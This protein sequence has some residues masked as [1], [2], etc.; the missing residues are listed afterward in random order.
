VS[1]NTGGVVAAWEWWVE[2]SYMGRNISAVHLNAAGVAAWPQGSVPVCDTPGDDLNPAV[3]RHGD[4][5]IV[6]FQ[7]GPYGTSAK[8]LAYQEL[9]GASGERRFAP[10]GVS[11]VPVHSGGDGFGTPVPMS[12]GRTALVWNNGTATH[13]R[14]LDNS[15]TPLPN[16]DTVGIVPD[17]TGLHIELYSGNTS[18]AQVCPDGSGG[19][20]ALENW[21]GDESGYEGFLGH[22]SSQGQP[23]NNGRAGLIWEGADVTD[24]GTMCVL[25]SPDSAGGC[26]VA[27]QL[28]YP[29]AG[30][31]VMRLNAD[32]QRVWN[33]PVQLDTIIWNQENETKVITT[34]DGSCIVAWPSY[35]G[36]RL[37]RV[38]AA[39]VKLWTTAVS[40]YSDWDLPHPK[41]AGDNQNGAYCT[42]LESVPDPSRYQV[43][44][45]HVNAVGA[46]LWPHGGIRVSTRESWQAQSRP[47]TDNAGNLIV[48]W[49]DYLSG[50]SGYD[51][52]AQ[53]IS[54]DNTRLWSDSGRVVCG[55]TGDQRNPVVIS[56]VAGGAYV[57][58]EDD[59][60]GNGKSH[61]SATHL[62]S[63][64]LSGPD[65][66]WV[67][68]EGGIIS[69]T[70][71][72][73]N[74]I[75]VLSAG[76]AG[77][78]VLFWQ[79]DFLQSESS[80]YDPYIQR[81]ALSGLAA[82]RPLSELSQSFQPHHADSL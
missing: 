68:N 37:A 66:Y 1:D 15:G 23:M 2:T 50:G 81:I 16:P 62:N 13:F 20:F 69:D 28:Y 82:V 76:E 42:W 4:G 32:C 30:L 56:D 26:Y 36:Y 31:F 10:Q 63:D 7:T 35:S 41:L 17:T 59:N 39:G 27:V 34:A 49:T 78:A 12:G 79:Q 74:V 44:A 21:G 6:V 58:W 60:D 48:I 61:I 43:H 46:E 57:A 72:N 5:F 9:D 53:K 70:I 80:Y 33:S 55:T 24:W 51:I 77:S 25:L 64:G 29:Q 11:L 14:I 67:Q 54:P 47:L 38:S 71:A 73:A 45:Q 19:F 22:V 18:L 3:V 52:R 40:D 65:P 8:A 75:P